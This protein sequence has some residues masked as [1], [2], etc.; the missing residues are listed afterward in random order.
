[1]REASWSQRVPGW[2]TRISKW[3]VAEGVM[4]AVVKVYS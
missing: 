3:L 1:M 2:T 4:A